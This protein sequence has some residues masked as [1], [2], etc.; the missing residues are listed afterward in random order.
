[1]LAIGLEAVPRPG[2]VSVEMADRNVHG[3][4]ATNRDPLRALLVETASHAAGACEHDPVAGQVNR[5]HVALWSLHDE[6]VTERRALH[7]DLA[8]SLG[9]RVVPCKPAE[10]GRE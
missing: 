3:G 7:D 9:R 8:G 2:P 4:R 10:R 5:R 1:M 6:M